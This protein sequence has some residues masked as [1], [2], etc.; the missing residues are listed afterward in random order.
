MILNMIIIII[1]LF[2]GSISN[3][4]P[5]MS[6]F[7]E[8]LIIYFLIKFIFLLLKKKQFSITRKEISII[9]LLIIYFSIGILSNVKSEIIINYSKFIVSGILSVKFIIIYLLTSI[10]FKNMKIN[11][12][13]LDKLYK[14]LNIIMNVYFFI[15]CINMPIGFLRS[16]GIRYK[17]INTVSVGFSH[18]AELDFLIISILIL[19]VF[20]TKLLN[21]SK[22]RYLFIL[23]EAFIIIIFTGR[24][25]AL[26]FFII[27]IISLYFSKYMKKLEVKYIIVSIPIVLYISKDR[28]ISELLNATGIRGILLNISIKIA[29]DYFPLGS[30]FGTFGSDLSRKIYSPLYSNYGIN[31]IWGLSENW[32]AYIT[33]SH[34]ASIIGEVGWLGTAVFLAILLIIFLIF[35]RSSKDSIYKLSTVSLFLYG[36]TSSLSDTILV[37]YRGVAIVIISN[38]IVEVVRNLN[39]NYIKNHE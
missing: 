25:K 14:I 17:I 24:S 31:N 37:S 28:I 36:L 34:W 22:K 23:V 19:Q 32:P 5:I 16:W 2:E 13:S 35:F 38:F 39:S 29:S 4:F 7:D 15:I 21:K 18:P 26:V 12:K 33:D 1:L 30:G 8:F 9:F 10:T 3:I 20:L 27:F 6:Y 11:Y